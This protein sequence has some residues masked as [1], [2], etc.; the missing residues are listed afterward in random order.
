MPD[1]SEPGIGEAILAIIIGII[2]GLLLVA[3]LVA[4]TT[5]CPIC[6]ERIKKRQNPCPHCHCSLRWPE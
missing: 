3:I 5:K 6:G 1:Q 2:F 4:G